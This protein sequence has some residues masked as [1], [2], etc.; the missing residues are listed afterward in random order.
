MLISICVSSLVK[1]VFKSGPK[2]LLVGSLL[3]SFK[4]FS[5]Y[6][7]FKS[8]KRHDSPIPSPSLTCHLL[9]VF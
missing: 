4:Y 6:L 8:F 3:L 9:Q 7:A 5:M 2:F 1:A